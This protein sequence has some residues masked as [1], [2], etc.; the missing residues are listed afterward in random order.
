MNMQSSTSNLWCG[1]FSL[2]KSWSH[3]AVAALIAIYVNL[4]HN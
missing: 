1:G 4:K 2:A 3:I